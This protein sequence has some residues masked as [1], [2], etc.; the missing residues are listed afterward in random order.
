MHCFATGD[1]E[2]DPPFLVTGRLLQIVILTQ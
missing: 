1:Q 2:K